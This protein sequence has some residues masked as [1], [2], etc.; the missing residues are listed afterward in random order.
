MA[1]ARFTAVGRVARS[2]LEA[3]E[4]EASV[5]SCRTASA[6]PKAAVTPISGAPRTRIARIASATASTE[7]SF[8]VSKKYGR[9]AWSMMWTESRAA[10]AQMLR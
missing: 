3:R 5:A 4:I 6:M 8:T 7:S 2:R 10:S 9:R 1:Q